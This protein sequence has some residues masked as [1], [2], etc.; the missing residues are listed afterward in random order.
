MYKRPY[1]LVCSH[2]DGSSWPKSIPVNSELAYISSLNFTS[3]WLRNNLQIINDW[4]DGFDITGCDRFP[5]SNFLEQDESSEDIICNDYFG[6]MDVLVRSVEPNLTLSAKYERNFLDDKFSGYMFKV[7]IKYPGFDVAASVCFHRV[8]SRRLFFCDCNPKSQKGMLTAWVKPF[9]HSIWLWLL[10]VFLL[11]SL[12]IGVTLH[13]GKKCSTESRIS[14]WAAVFLTVAGLYL[15]QEGANSGCPSLLLLSSLCIGVILSLYENIVT[16]ELV[17]PPEKFEHNLSSLLMAAG[18]IVIYSGSKLPT[19][20]DLIDLKI[21]TKKWNIKYSMDQFQLNNELHD[22]NLPLQNAT[23]LSYFGYYSSVESDLRIRNSKLVNNKCHC[24]IVK[25]PFS[26]RVT[27]FI[28][29]HFLRNKFASVFNTLRENGIYYFFTERDRKYG[30][31]IYLARSRRELEANQSHS[32][33][34]VREE[35][36]MALIEL[37]NL[38]FIFVAFGGM[39]LFAFIIFTLKQMDWLALYIYCKGL[40]LKQ[41]HAIRIVNYVSLFNRLCKFRLIRK[42]LNWR[43]WRLSICHPEHNS[44]RNLSSTEEDSKMFARNS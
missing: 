42:D 24:Y 40:V 15:R 38:Y 17:V 4:Y 5:W 27:H 14:D 36:K 31:N 30:F 9:E 39:V 20:Q 44:P 19:N 22:K 21:E 41:L 33:F 1:V 3:S 32:D 35:S 6:F 43:N 7:H 34:F 37:E 29:R 16:S 13:T 23:S 28:F 25:H 11:L 2:C 12:T 10:I 26:K 8:S 18:S